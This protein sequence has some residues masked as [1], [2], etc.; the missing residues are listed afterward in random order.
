MNIERWNRRGNSN[1]GV[2]NTPTNENSFDTPSLLLDRN[3]YRL[4]KIKQP[5][6]K[7]KCEGAFTYATSTH[8]IQ[9][10]PNEAT[11]IQSKHIPRIADKWRKLVFFFFDKN[12]SSQTKTFSALKAKSDIS[13]CPK[14]LN[15]N[16][17]LKINIKGWRGHFAKKGNSNAMRLA[18]KVMTQRVIISQDKTTRLLL[19]ALV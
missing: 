11:Y 4:K 15:Y 8:S 2:I 19:G 10:E 13:R 16:N 7:S 5:A 3:A 17:F 6:G 18:G 14:I 9:S 1:E 12:I